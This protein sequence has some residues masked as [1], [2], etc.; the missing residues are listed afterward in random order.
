MTK[1]VLVDEKRMFL[2]KVTRKSVTCE[3][4]SW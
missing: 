1:K 3:I 2:E 4:F